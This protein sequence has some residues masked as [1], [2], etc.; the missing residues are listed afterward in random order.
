MLELAASLSR[1]LGCNDERDT[2]EQLIGIFNLLSAW[3][4][5]RRPVN[6]GLRQ[7]LITFSIPAG[8]LFPGYFMLRGNNELCA[9]VASISCT[10]NAARSTASAD[11]P[12]GP[13]VPKPNPAAATATSPRTQRRAVGGGA[14]ILA[15]PCPS[16]RDCTQSQSAHV[17]VV[18]L[19]LCR[20]A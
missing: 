5:V 1:A 15:T 12:V 11:S 10:V 6:V 16:N 8:T 7:C 2:K 13:V 9:T 18:P 14:V 3:V 17:V 19:R 4:N 20:S